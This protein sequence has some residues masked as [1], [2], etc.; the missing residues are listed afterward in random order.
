MDI[1][2]PI[3]ETRSIESTG[4]PVH[5]SDGTHSLP[6]RERE[7]LLGHWRREQGAQPTGW[8]FSA[9]DGRMSTD[10]TP[11][12]LDAEYRL[13]LADVRHVLDMGT[14]GGEHLLRFADA[15]PTDT[16][17]TEGWPPNVP[18]A[19]QALNGRGIAVVEFSA[20]DD[21]P[22]SVPMPFPDARFDLVLNRHESYSA[23]E[24]ARVLAPGGVFL[25]QQVGSGEL[26]ELH[27]L[28]GVEPST[29]EVTLQR[30]REEVEDA[31]LVIERSDEFDGWY[32]FA[33][34]AALIAYLNC[35]PWEVP[36]DFS[37]D[38]YAHAL[39]SLHEQAGGGP[40]LL[41]MR[42]FWLRARRPHR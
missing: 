6:V 31:G 19:R 21:E 32:R 35:V 4:G 30:F 18:I 36:A 27:R 24:V 8:D 14:G 34:V 12:D 39:L 1:H 41:E 20:P 28:I 23:R 2:K 11:W 5:R 29:D 16:M 37:V 26:T 3:D 25:T 7:R 22:N 17:A 42:R 40:L 13:A 38:R 15:L 33:D 9:L 10:P